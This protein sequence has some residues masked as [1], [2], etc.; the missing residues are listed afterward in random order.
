MVLVFD[1]LEL[2]EKIVICICTGCSV[3]SWRKVENVLV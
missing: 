1:S 3:M 2:R